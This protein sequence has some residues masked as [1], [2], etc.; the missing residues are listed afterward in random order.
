MK[1][2]E[3]VEDIT[4]IANP[5]ISATEEA[6]LIATPVSSKVGGESSDG[7]H[8]A[9]VTPPSPTMAFQMVKTPLCEHVMGG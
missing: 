6:V 1:E 3:Q 9:K 4:A 5:P 7:R 8:V 2:V